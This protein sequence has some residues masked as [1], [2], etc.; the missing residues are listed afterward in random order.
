MECVDLGFLC[1]RK[2]KLHNCETS[3]NW[4]KRSVSKDKTMH[5]QD[6][7]CNF[8]LVKRRSNNYLK[9]TRAVA[10]TVRSISF[11]AIDVPHQK[12]RLEPTGLERVPMVMN[13]RFGF[14]QHSDLV[15]INLHR[16]AS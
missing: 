1:S 4:S 7:M 13:K 9:A 8:T 16:K 15:I 12:K 2:V 11:V 14:E 6:V 3:E 5:M 10:S